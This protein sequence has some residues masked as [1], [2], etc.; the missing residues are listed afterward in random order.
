L[1]K[2]PYRSRDP[3]VAKGEIRSVRQFAESPRRSPTGKTVTVYG[4]TE[5]TLDLV[6]ARDVIGAP[7]VYEALDVAVHDIESDHPSDLQ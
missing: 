4:Q 2:T 5:V 7:T 3:G 6:N 1:V